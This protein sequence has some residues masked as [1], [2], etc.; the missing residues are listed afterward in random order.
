MANLEVIRRRVKQEFGY[1]IVTIEL[2]DKYIDEIIQ[3]SLEFLNDY[4]PELNAV[5]THTREG[6]SIPLSDINFVHRVLKVV[7]SDTNDSQSAVGG[8]SQEA[9]FS[10]QSSYRSVGGSYGYPIPGYSYSTS[11]MIN[12][13]VNKAKISTEESLIFSVVND[14]VYIPNTI[15]IVTLY[16]IPVW[17]IE[18]LDAYWQKKLVTHASCTMKKLVGQARDKYKSSKQLYELHSTY[19]EGEQGLE[20]LIEELTEGKLILGEIV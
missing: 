13:L 7:K 8:P 12:K 10:K 17:K 19:E 18:D 6:N 3:D 20:K 16:Y 2:E 1:P 15:G 4:S 14:R 11:Y 5:T 9:L